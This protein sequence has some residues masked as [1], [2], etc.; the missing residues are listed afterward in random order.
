MLYEDDPYLKFVHQEALKQ[1]KIFLLDSGEGR[2][3]VD[4]QTGWHVEDLSGWLI[5]PA[6]HEKFITS[7]KNGT[8]YDDFSDEY[9]FAIWSKSDCGE[10]KIDF[11]K[12]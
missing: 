11:K 2:G 7:R 3:F 8:A 10:L 4:A 5:A 1:E 6:S 12:Y 9:V